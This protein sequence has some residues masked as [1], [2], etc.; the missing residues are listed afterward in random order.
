LAR[1]CD[2]FANTLEEKA[3]LAL[4]CQQENLILCQYTSREIQSSA[5]TSARKCDFFVDTTE[6]KENI[7]SKCR[8]EDVFYFPIRRRRNPI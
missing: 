7:V 2:Y 4:K 1:K 8:Q 5:K 6:E 3:N